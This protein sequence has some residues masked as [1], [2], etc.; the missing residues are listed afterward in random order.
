MY[1]CIYVCNDFAQPESRRPGRR[2][3]GPGSKGVNRKEDGENNPWSTST[4]QYLTRIW[5]LCVLGHVEKVTSRAW[6]FIHNAYYNFILVGGH[7]AP[8]FVLAG[9]TKPKIGWYQQND[10][11]VIFNDNHYNSHDKRGLAKLI[12]WVKAPSGRLTNRYYRHV[13]RALEGQG[14]TKMFVYVVMLYFLF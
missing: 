13:P 2:A 10:Q 11:L 9:L 14:P 3:T 7:L 6:R 4:E 12:K 8:I 5:T 1:V